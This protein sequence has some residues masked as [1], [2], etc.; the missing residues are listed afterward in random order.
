MA[1]RPLL[2]EPGQSTT[3]IIAKKK[4]MNR[5]QALDLSISLSSV[6]L[7]A[8]GHWI[9]PLSLFFPSSLS[10]N[11]FVTLSAAILLSLSLF[12]LSLSTKLS[13]RAAR[14]RDGDG[15][16]C[17]ETMNLICMAWHVHGT[18]VFLNLA[19]L[20]VYSFLAFYLVFSSCTH[21]TL[22]RGARKK[23]QGVG[24]ERERK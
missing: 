15:M 6:S 10:T 3:G 20:R 24:R 7:Y 12:A 14:E 4:K 17:G 21:T 2:L 23:I 22:L 19:C 1:P 11:P 8:S 9:C 5:F 13:A 18:G 16:G